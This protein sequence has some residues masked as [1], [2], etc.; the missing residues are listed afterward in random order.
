MTAYSSNQLS[1]FL[2]HHSLS[3]PHMSLKEGHLDNKI[4]SVKYISLQTVHK[5]A[6]KLLLHVRKKKLLLKQHQYFFF[7]INGN[8]N[9]AEVE[10][11]TVTEIKNIFFFSHTY[12]EET[13]LCRKNILSEVFH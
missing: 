12:N 7:E 3:H 9:M 10:T 11:E 1:T 5:I 6:I 13:L 8:E 2:S 4:H